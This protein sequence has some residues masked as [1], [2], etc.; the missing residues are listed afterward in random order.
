MPKAETKLGIPSVWNNEK[1]FS[2]MDKIS[3]VIITNLVL[4]HQ[5]I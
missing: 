2:E 3:E 5:S 1:V 4:G